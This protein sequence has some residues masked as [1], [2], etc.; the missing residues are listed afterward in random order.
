MSKADISTPANFV[1]VSGVKDGKMVENTDAVDPA[2]RD[3]LH[4]A[5]LSDNVL[6][7]PKKKEE[8]YS[9]VKSNDVGNLMSNN[10]YRVYTT[11]IIA[12]WL[13]FS[14]NDSQLTQL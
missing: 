7:D 1:H 2:I 13:T 3:F 5:G 11:G 10:R 4:I 8:I 14:Q 9:F 12:K 6:A